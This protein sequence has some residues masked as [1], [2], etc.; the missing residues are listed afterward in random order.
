M[1]PQIDGSSQRATA[2]VPVLVGIDSLYLSSFLSGLSIDW[3]RLRYEKEKLRVTPRLVLS[4]IELGGERFALKRGGR[5]SPELW[6]SDV[7]GK[8]RKR[9]F[10]L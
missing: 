3:E 1:S 7:I 5:H 2:L 4:E 10:G 8:V 6:R 9:A